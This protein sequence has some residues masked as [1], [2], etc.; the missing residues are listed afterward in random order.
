MNRV[1]RWQL[2]GAVVALT[3]SSATS[4]RAQQFGG[5]DLT[6]DTDYRPTLAVIGIGV[7][8]EVAPGD[9]NKL[10]LERIAQLWVSGLTRTNAFAQVLTPSEAKERLA[11]DHGAALDCADAECLKSA[12]SQLDVH[13]V[14]SGHLSVGEEGYVLKL[15]RLIRYQNAFDSV[16]LPVRTRSELERQSAAAV[17]ELSRPAAVLLGTLKVKSATPNATAVLN[18]TPLGV[19]PAERTVP[20]GRYTL[21][22]QAQGFLPDELEANVEPAKVVELETNLVN[23]PAEV[24]QYVEPAESTV[25]TSVGGVWKRPG[26]YL[27]AGGVALAAVGVALGMGAKS[28]ERRATD[29]NGD[30]VLDI[31]RQERNTAQRNAMLS[32]VLVGTGAAAAVGGAVWFFLTPEPAREAGPLEASWRGGVVVAG[33]FP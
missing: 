19:L 25:E 11:D 6:D 13:V 29:A 9:A 31:T 20:S 26:L 32:N 7:A 21:R 18:D 12:A 5:L 33:S 24:A 10:R 2:W 30:G 22:V 14:L 3:L 16:E 27:A 17:A 15:H 1:H 8:D 28:I 23:K 4:A